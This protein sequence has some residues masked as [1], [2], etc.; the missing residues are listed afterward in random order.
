MFI[1]VQT[2]RRYNRVKRPVIRACVKWRRVFEGMALEGDEIEGK[3][4][5]DLEVRKPT[6]HQLRVKSGPSGKAQVEEWYR[7]R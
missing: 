2:Y 6:I 7:Y 4:H 5:H 1:G 3:V